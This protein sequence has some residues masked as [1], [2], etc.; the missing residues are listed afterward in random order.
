[1]IKAVL[2]CERVLGLI[3][4]IR[5]HYDAGFPLRVTS[6]NALIEIKSAF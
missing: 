5:T 1:M 3:G 6:G 4:A 2:F